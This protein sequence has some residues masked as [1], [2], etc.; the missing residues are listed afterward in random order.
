VKVF[1][2]VIILS[3]LL[4][5][6]F[7]G[8]GRNDIGGSLPML[9]IN[10]E[11]GRDGGILFP[12]DFGEQPGV[13]SADAVRARIGD[14]QPIPKAVAALMLE[15]EGFEV[16][17]LGLAMGVGDYLTLGQAQE[18][19]TML[20]PT[21]MGLSI[22][23][24]NSSRLISYALWVDL[25]LG[26]LDK[27]GKTD[28]LEA[29]NIIPFRHDDAGVFTN[30]GVFDSTGIG[31]DLAAFS[32][33]EIQVMRRGDRIVAV[34]GLTDSTPVIR[35][36]LILNSDIL[37]VTVF[38]GGV[39]RNYAY[40]DG[41]TM[42]PEGTVIASVR[43]N[44]QLVVAAAPSEAVV[45]GTIERVTGQYIELREW[46]TLPLCW[47]FAVYG[48][49]GEGREAVL[50][51]P[52]DLLVGAD[53]ADFHV[54]EGRVIAA[55]I[56]RD[57]APTYIRVVIGTSGF[58]G[59][60]HD[61]VTITSTGTFTVRGGDR[62]ERIAAGASFT[63]NS[64]QNADFWGGVRFYI[65]PEN[66]EHRLEI[67]ELRRNWP[68]GEYPRYRGTMEI[69]QMNNGFII[70]NE[71]PLEEYLY[72]VV[73]SEMPSFHGLEAAKVQ[74][75]TARSFAYHQFYQN[76]FRAFGAHVDDSVSSQVYNNIPEN[77]LSIEAVTSTAGQVITYNGQVILAN[78]FSTSGGT[79]ANFGEVWA[80]GSQFPSQSPAYLRSLPQFDLN[81]HS[82]DNLTQERYADAFF[83]NTNIP[84]FD[85]NFPWFR[86]QVRMT[87]V[88]LS[89]SINSRLATRQAANP[90][91]IQVYPPAQSIGTLR[92]IEIIRRGEGGNIME[93]LLVGTEAS[94]RVKTEF[95][96]RS[97][98]HPGDAPVTRH[99]GTTVSQLSLMPSAFF[100]IDKETDTG[101]NLVA[102]TFF[103]G[104]NGHG[105][106]MSQNGARALL[107]LGF[108][109]QDVLRHYYPG[110]VIMIISDLE[111]ISG[112]DG[113]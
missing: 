13:A 65:S 16:G 100:T 11:D 1:F 14:S 88:E 21:G 112:F 59:L 34:I 96:I 63:V 45:R 56:T 6:F 97:L 37:G 103:G 27:L 78:Y 53:M 39:Q 19:M 89:N 55:V 105:V 18:K 71:L 44:R 85:R 111:T 54:R 51:S 67:V 61:N 75:V 57:V 92:D 91:L 49:V 43:V 106:G 22:T 33:M 72:A 79:T 24:E 109:Y 108:T 81:Q 23:E 48:L 84:G 86:W 94:A 73:P 60:V 15:N 64:N 28:G 70:I 2:Y 66:P 26:L 58:T 38:S 98:L 46:G 104:G 17:D 31:L 32:D 29:V 107:D 110:T 20:N 30:M 36:A 82:P 41:V 47:A 102:I 35:N 42:L 5:L 62:T 4:G 87:A 77:E 99:D 76:R 68:N 69:S 83:R 9:V 101:G 93:I 3:V 95:N 52:H 74:A 12:F 10:W 8:C 90:A 113:S 7:S 50:K 80:V 25:F 40:S